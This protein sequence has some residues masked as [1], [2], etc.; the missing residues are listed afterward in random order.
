MGSARWKFK[1]KDVQSLLRNKAGFGREPLPCAKESSEVIM[2]WASSPL[3]SADP[4]C[5]A[6]VAA[7]RRCEV[8]MGN[9]GP[10]K[11]RAAMKSSLIYTLLRYANSPGGKAEIM[12]GL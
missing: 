2:C 4:K 1:P 8:A 12:R 6:A 10:A 5:G 9:R 7:L 3:Q 11:A